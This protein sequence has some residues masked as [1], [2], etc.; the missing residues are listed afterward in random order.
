M[1]GL[2]EN[3]APDAFWSQRIDDVVAR[4]VEIVR[5]VRPQVVVTYDPFGNTGHPDHVQ[6]HRVT[7]LAVQAAVEPWC[8]AAA[9]P[10]WT[11]QQVFHPVYPESALQ[12]FIDEEVE[13]GRA[14]PFESRAATA[15]NYCRPDASVTH[16]VDIRD[17]HARKAAALHSH[18]TQVG[19]HYPLLYR[20][21]LARR[22]Y[23]HFRLT[24]QAGSAGGFGDVFEPVGS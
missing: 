3:N 23:E 18:R 19:P 4:L 9:G 22:D 7:V 2:P 11:V 1:T 5:S 24:W 6:A 17:V 12:Q 21:A 13:T 15:I 20:A 10:A 8:Y 16:R 14:H